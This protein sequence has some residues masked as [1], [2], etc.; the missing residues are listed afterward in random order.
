VAFA[1]WHL[2]ERAWG[3][4]ALA[5]RTRIQTVHYRR[6]VAGINVELLMLLFWTPQGLCCLILRRAD[7]VPRC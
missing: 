3:D 5:A 7:H 6:I 1:R 4:V 2:G